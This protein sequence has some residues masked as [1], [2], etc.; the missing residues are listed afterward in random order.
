L[1]EEN[2]VSVGDKLKLVMVLIHQ[3]LTTSVVRNWIDECA[4][5]LVTA[6]RNLK[7]HQMALQRRNRDETLFWC[8]KTPLFRS[9]F[10]T[11]HSS[12]E[13]ARL[14]YFVRVVKY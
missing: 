1:P 11:Y 2:D 10:L 4:K 5:R 6:Q 7:F 14:K 3:L 9:P 12:R 13:I 8:V